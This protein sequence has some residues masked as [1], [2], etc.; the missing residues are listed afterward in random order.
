[1]SAFYKTL[2]QNASTRT[3]FDTLLS[4]VILFT[5]PNKLYA[6]NVTTSIV[7]KTY[8]EALYTSVHMVFQVVFHTQ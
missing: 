4:N 7:S 8:M 5:C 6:H 2:P 1:M 3:V